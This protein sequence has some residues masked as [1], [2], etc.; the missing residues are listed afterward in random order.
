MKRKNHGTL[1]KSSLVAGEQ[2]KTYIPEPLPPVPAIG[3]PEIAEWLAKANFAIGELNGITENFPDP[4]VINYMYVRKEAVVS[5]QIEGTQSTLD[6]LLRYESSI[7]TGVP[8]DD[9]SEVSSYVAALN[10]GMKRMNGGFPLSVRLIREIHKILLTNS[11]GR[12]K[13]PGEIRRSQNWLGGTRPGNAVFVPAPP[14]LVSGLLSDL[15]RYMHS[16]KKIP[17]LVK[18]ALIH[19]QFETIHPFLDGNGRTG[20]LLITLFLYAQG[21]LCSPFLYLSLFFKRHR[22]L[23]YEKLYYVRKTGDWESWIN[24]F[25]EGAAVTATDA[26]KTLLAI[27]KKFIADDEKISELGRHRASVAAIFAIFKNKPLLTIAEITQQTSFTK[28][29][30]MSAVNRLIALGIIENKSDKK[31]RQIFVYSGYVALLAP[32]TE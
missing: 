30:A 1:V 20:R 19:Q 29:T 27:Q 13:T 25:L 21:F 28:P 2:Y 8:L 4:S 22:K 5:S 14:D 18:A 16:M 9:V 31:W 32:G 26:K 11:R 6:D 3:M 17:V 23:Y 10:H 24:F 15:E 7:A 12:H